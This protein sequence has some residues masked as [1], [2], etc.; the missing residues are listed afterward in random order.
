MQLYFFFSSKDDGYDE[1]GNKLKMC[2]QLHANLKKFGYIY[3]HDCK[4][5]FLT[6][7]TTVQT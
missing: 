1:N 4:Q 6:R 5:Y 2:L 7:H 3:I